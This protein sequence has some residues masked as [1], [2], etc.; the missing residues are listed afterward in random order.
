MSGHQCHI[1][2]QVPPESR[3]PTASSPLRL[4]GAD[5]RTL[6]G[7]RPSASISLYDAIAPAAVC[8]R[9]AHDLLGMCQRFVLWFTRLS[10]VICDVRKVQRKNGAYAGQ[11]EVRRRRKEKPRPGTNPG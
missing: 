11:E 9:L 10:G 4:P 8:E 2:L 7:S 5:E 1:Q 3:A 6:T